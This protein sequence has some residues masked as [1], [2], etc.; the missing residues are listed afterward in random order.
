MQASHMY[1]SSFLCSL[2]LEKIKYMYYLKACA[3]CLSRQFLFNFKKARHVWVS[4][5]LNFSLIWKLYRNLFYHYK[6]KWDLFGQVIL[7]SYSCR[8]GVFF[9]KL[10]AKLKQTVSLFVTSRN[11]S[12]LGEYE[13]N[14]F[15]DLKYVY[16]FFIL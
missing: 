7:A 13:F 1:L 10:P 9:R 16:R 6:I 5:S 4:M 2:F 11:N 8:F 15:S 14:F 12:C 3:D